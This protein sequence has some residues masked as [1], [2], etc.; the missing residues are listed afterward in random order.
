VKNYIQEGE[1]LNLIAPYAVSSGGGAIVGSIFG[2][3]STD[4]ANGE[5]GVFQLQ[6][7]YHLAKST[8]ASSGGSQGAKAYFIAS[9]KLVTAVASSNTL[10][11]VFTAT[12]ADADTTAQVRL[13]GSFH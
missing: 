12:C 3:A 5:E 13:N 2:V 1:S 7:V 6:G 11:G 10:I 4:L 8:A 9:T